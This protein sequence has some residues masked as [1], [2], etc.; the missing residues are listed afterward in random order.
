MRLRSFPPWGRE[1]KVMSTPGSTCASHSFGS[2]S[3]TN[4]TDSVLPLTDVGVP[5]PLESAFSRL[6]ISFPH[7]LGVEFALPVLRYEQW[8]FADSDAVSESAQFRFRWSPHGL[9]HGL[10]FLY[11]PEAFNAISLIWKPTPT[12]NQ[13]RRF[14]TDHKLE[15]NELGLPEQWEPWGLASSGEWRRRRRRRRPGAAEIH[16]WAAAWSREYTSAS[17]NRELKS[18][19]G[20]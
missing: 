13:R 18:T 16:C 10:Q 14:E 7:I 2:S 19:P 6:S 15:R 1:T 5:S 11:A 3:S 20:S 4:T 17:R 8:N 12:L 9:A